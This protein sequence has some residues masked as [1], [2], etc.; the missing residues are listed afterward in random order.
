MKP[1]ANAARELKIASKS[2]TRLSG[3]G[4]SRQRKYAE[5]DLTP[6]EFRDQF[7]RLLK[8]APDG[9]VGEYHFVDCPADRACWTK[10]GIELEAGARVTTMAICHLNESRKSG[11]CAGMLFQL[12]MRVGSTE[13]IFHGGRNTRSFVTPESGKLHVAVCPPADSSAER[14]RLTMP[15]EDGSHAGE[16]ISIVAI[17]WKDSSLRGLRHLANIGDVQ[18]LVRTEIDRLCNPINTVGG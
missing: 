15:V 1:F 2:S 10:T 11:A 7:S 18:G 14:A 16:T 13:M 5:S 9:V 3:N 8:K 6:E 12:G 4:L 17:R